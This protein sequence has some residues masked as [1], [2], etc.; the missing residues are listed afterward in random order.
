MRKA[1]PEEN[2]N[3][4]AN[5]AGQL[6]RFAHEAESN[7]WVVSYDQGNRQ[8]LVGRMNGGYRYAPS[9]FSEYP[10]VRGV[11]WSGKIPRSILSV[12]ARNS[13]GAT[14][15]VFEI[16]DYIPEFQDALAGRQPTAPTTSVP[17]P[18][19][20]DY[21]REVQERAE[22]IISDNLDRLDGYSFQDLVGGLLRAM[23]YRTQ[24]SPRGPD[25]GIDIRAG[26]DGLLLTDPIIRV[27]VKHR[28][29]RVGAPEIQQLVGSIGG[30]GRGLFVS[31][32]GFT[33][34]ARRE[35]DRA[36]KPITLLD[37]E[38]FVNLLTEHYEELDVEL[39]DLVP[40]KRVW[41]PART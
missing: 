11:T 27:Q 15:T 38:D 10:H 36:S 31:T 5:F 23:G 9:E 28:K 34:D 14:Q 33:K 30:G 25:G 3:R 17:L 26:T 29:G 4:L 16:T 8:Y 39:R 24:E 7:D 32:G 19:G 20:E 35:A 6:Y 40:L 37:G 1:N 18:P 21:Y 2:A 22:G 13:L 41:L 12:D